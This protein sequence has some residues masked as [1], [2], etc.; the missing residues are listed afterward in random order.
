MLKEDCIELINSG[1]EFGDFKSHSGLNLT[2]RFDVISLL[3]VQGELMDHISPMFRT[4]GIEVGGMLLSCAYEG[5]LAG[6]IRKES[7]GDKV[8][9]PQF[10]YSRYNPSEY[11][12]VTL[13]D[14]VVTTEV[15]IKRAALVLHQHKIKVGEYLCIVDRRPDHLKSL[16]I[17]SITNHKELGLPEL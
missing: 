14:D 11:P 3:S 6:I 15:S 8:Y 4:I 10:Y 16:K 7:E 9:E 1:I 5:S 17:T 12:I 13:V 2:W